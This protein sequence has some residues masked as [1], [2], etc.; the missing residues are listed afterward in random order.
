MRL[1]C[2]RI[3][4]NRIA[5]RSHGHFGLELPK[6]LLLVLLLSMHRYFAFD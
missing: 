4:V 5:A 1:E 2:Q 6:F 3:A